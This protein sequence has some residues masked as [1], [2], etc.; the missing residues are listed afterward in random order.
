M[1]RFM[2]DKDGAPMSEI[3]E[4]PEPKKRRG[5]PPLCYSEKKEGKRQ[6]VDPANLLETINVIEQRDPDAKAYVAKLE[7][8][9]AYKN[10]LLT[11]LEMQK[12]AQSDS[13]GTEESRLTLSPAQQETM[14]RAIAGQSTPTDCADIG[15]VCGALGG[16][17][18]RA[19][20]GDASNA[21]VSSEE[22]Y[23]WGV[24]GKISRNVFLYL[25]TRPW[26][27]S[28]PPSPPRRPS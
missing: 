7:R 26:S 13:Q 6:K 11:E 19:L 25:T 2:L 20:G 28:L 21:V 15:R 8:D 4:T 16:A 14:N 5:R 9:L 23:Q 17:L 3:P 27:D 12:Q 1:W 24:L 10:Q 18:G 22:R